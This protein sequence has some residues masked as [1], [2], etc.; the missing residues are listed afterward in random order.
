MQPFFL[1]SG[2]VVK[3]SQVAQLLIR[4]TLLQNSV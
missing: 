2:K 1:E 4:K 3:P